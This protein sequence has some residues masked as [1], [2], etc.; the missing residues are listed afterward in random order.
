MTKNRETK[1]YPPLLTLIEL[2]DKLLDISH[3]LLSAIKLNKQMADIN[4]AMIDKHESRLNKVEKDSGIAKAV[5]AVDTPDEKQSKHTWTKIGNLNWSE[6]LGKMTWDQAKEKCQELGGRLPTRVEL[7]DLYDNHSQCREMENCCWSSTEYN[8]SNAWNVTF[9][10]G[11]ATY[12]YKYNS[13][14]VRCVRDIKE[15]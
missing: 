5:S 7:I 2:N 14:S 3:S 15:L 4:H 10:N 8:S 1:E 11:N 13:F 6:D 12:N 9:Y